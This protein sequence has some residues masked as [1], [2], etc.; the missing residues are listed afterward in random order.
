MTE[1]EKDALWSDVSDIYSSDDTDIEK[2]KQ[3]YS[4]AFDAVSNH[5]EEPEDSYDDYDDDYEAYYED[6]DFS[7]SEDSSSEE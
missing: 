2:C 1:A 3:F 4:V 5:Y 7:N 6:N